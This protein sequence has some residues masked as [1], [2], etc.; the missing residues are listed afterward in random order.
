M[1]LAWPTPAEILASSIPAFL[2]FRVAER[3]GSLA[4]GMETPERVSRQRAAQADEPGASNRQ[5]GE[6]PSRSCRLEAE[7]DV[8]PVAGEVPRDERR[9]RDVAHQQELGR[10]GA[11]E[12]GRTA[13]A[14]QFPACSGGEAPAVGLDGLESGP[15]VR[16]MARLGEEGPDV[17]A[18]GEQLP[19]RLN[20]RHGSRPGSRG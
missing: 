13:A 3:R 1:P 15:P 14:A 12:E 20:A 2:D 6:C 10:A 11:A 16:K 5:A 7:L 9:L 17:L 8:E 18:L 19:L 4:Q